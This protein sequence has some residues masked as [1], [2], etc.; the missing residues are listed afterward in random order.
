MLG[1]RNLQGVEACAIVV[2][3][4]Q[5]FA[6]VDCR[7][8]RELAVAEELAGV[9]RLSRGCGTST[10]AAC[11]C[12]QAQT[13]GTCCLQGTHLLKDKLKEHFKGLEAWTFACSMCVVLSC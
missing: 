12:V 9:V 6:G 3:H 11:A 10:T 2:T 13:S 5:V 1:L 7:D 4:L 8:S